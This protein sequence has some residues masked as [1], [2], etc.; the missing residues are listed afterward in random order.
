[1]FHF[2]VFN[3]ETA[4]VKIWNSIDLYWLSSSVMWKKICNEWSFKTLK[5][6]NVSIWPLQTVWE[7]WK[8]KW[9]VLMAVV[10]TGWAA[11]LRGPPGKTWRPAHLRGECR[12]MVR[13]CAL[14][15]F[16]RVKMCTRGCRSARRRR[17]HA[18]LTACGGGEILAARGRF[19]I[20]SA[21][22]VGGGAHL[23]WSSN[24]IV[25][26]E[27]FNWWRTWESIQ[28][29]ENIDIVTFQ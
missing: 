29:W 13:P 3:L 26:R 12:C 7:V 1:M 11:I 2:L 18:R 9:K 8:F 4:S 22:G 27:I 25:N 5:F 14:R 17:W 28:I 23:L 15:E 24:T 19:A 6:R 16:L 10:V 20:V 21:A